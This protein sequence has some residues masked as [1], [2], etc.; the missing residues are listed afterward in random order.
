MEYCAFLLINIV[1][2]RNRQS[3]HRGLFPMRLLR[4]FDT[5][6]RYG[7]DEEPLSLQSLLPRMI[8]EL[9]L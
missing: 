6:R 7:Y 8:G 5:L 1:D 4:P 9:S 2:I 3:N